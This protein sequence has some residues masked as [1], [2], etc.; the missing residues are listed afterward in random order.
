MK[1]M[2]CYTHIHF[3]Q[4]CLILICL[5]LN[6]NGMDRKSRKYISLVTQREVSS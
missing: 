4:I 6:L 3:Q 5:I 1:I 2:Y